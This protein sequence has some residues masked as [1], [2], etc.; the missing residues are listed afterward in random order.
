MGSLS[1][2]EVLFLDSNQ[3]SGRIPNQLG[4]LSNLNMISLSENSELT[5]CIHSEPRGVE[6]ND[7]ADTG[8]DFCGGL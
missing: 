4:S 5:G 6:I 8:L 3:L 1:N 7:F 2:L